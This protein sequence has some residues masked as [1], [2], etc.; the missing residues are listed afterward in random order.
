MEMFTTHFAIRQIMKKE[1]RKET[2]TER[3]KGKE[4]RNGNKREK[5]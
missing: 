5:K 2:A 3:R 4:K 1:R